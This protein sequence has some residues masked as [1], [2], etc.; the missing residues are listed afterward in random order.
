[1][2]G[3]LQQDIIDYLRKHGPTPQSE[4]LQVVGDATPANRGYLGQLL[5]GMED[6]QVIERDLGAPGTDPI[7]VLR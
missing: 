2:N 5:S 3:S 1:M 4:L 7:V 6:A